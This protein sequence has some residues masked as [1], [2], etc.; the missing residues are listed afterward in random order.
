MKANPA[1]KVRGANPPF[2]P[3]QVY[4]TAGARLLDFYAG[5]APAAPDWFE[6]AQRDPL[7]RLARWRFTYAEAMLR[8]RN[9]LR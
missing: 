9:R 3:T 8:E 1:A 2:F 7:V 4:E 5:L 6:P